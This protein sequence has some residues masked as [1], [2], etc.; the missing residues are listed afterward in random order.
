MSM[1]THEDGPSA[2]STRTLEIITSLFFLALGA[3]VMWVQAG[4][5]MGQK[6]ATSRFT[7]VC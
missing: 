3:V 2:A 1:E 5:M 4:A 6:V 7:S